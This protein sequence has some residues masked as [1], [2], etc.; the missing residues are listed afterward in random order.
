MIGK[1]VLI[2]NLINRINKK[3]IRNSR[4]GNC[5]L[6]IRKKE[7]GIRKNRMRYLEKT[8]KK[9]NNSI[10]NRISVK[11]QQRQTKRK[12]HKTRETKEIKQ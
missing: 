3:L 1:L 6:I 8:N 11:I 7:I 12:K 9:N 10:L 2:R 5:W 4:N